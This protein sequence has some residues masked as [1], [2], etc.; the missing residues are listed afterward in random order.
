MKFKKKKKEEDHSRLRLSFHV[1]YFFVHLLYNGLN[2]IKILFAL[3]E[4]KNKI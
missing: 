1:F 4:R 2:K 3:V